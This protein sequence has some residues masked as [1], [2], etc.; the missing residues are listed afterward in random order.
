MGAGIKKTYPEFLGP[1]YA[2]RCVILSLQKR[3]DAGNLERKT[4]LT[5]WR[6]SVSR[7]K[8]TQVPAVLL[9][10]WSK[11]CICSHVCAHTH[12]HT[13]PHNSTYTE[14]THIDRSSNTHTQTH[15]KAAKHPQGSRHLAPAYQLTLINTLLLALAYHSLSTQKDWSCSS[16]SLRLVANRPTCWVCGMSDMCR[17]FRLLMCV[18]VVQGMLDVF[19]VCLMCEMCSGSWC[20]L[21]LFRVCLMCLECV[22]CVQG[23]FDVC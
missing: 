11:T 1:K 20:V 14:G 18:K 21:R 2:V 23:V 19:R 3:S 17:V 8:I 16:E 7:T 22:R 9:H 6:N 15:F 12:T 13:H 10:Q 4:L 5:S